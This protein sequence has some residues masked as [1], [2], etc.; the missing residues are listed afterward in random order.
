MPTED[1]PVNDTLI[2][3]DDLHKHYQNTVAVSG[4]N[5][6]VRAGQILGLVGPNGAGKTTIIR[7]ACG[8]HPPTQG[9]I[10]IADWDVV[11][12][13]VQAKRQ[14]AYVPDDPKLFNTLTVWEHL[15]F[16][17][18]AYNIKDE[19]ERRGEALL[20]QFELTEKR[21][22][23]AEEL[24]RGMR[25]KLAICC[26]YL[27]EPQALFLDEPLT[28]LDPRGMRTMKDS[29]RAQAERGSAIVISSHLL[30]LVE[31]MC[32]DLLVLHRGQRL[33]FGPLDQ[34]RDHAGAAMQDATLEDIFLH[35][36]E[37]GTT[38]P[39]EPSDA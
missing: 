27:H 4:V 19:L 26:A 28:G 25:Q 37:E 5:F 29:I 1:P 18:S 36:T 38:E 10:A 11:T 20:T 2:R 31:D 35:M 32:S 7:A 9:R 13:P 6:H 21:H 23:P 30:S 33:Y 3:V 8:I 14:L 12:H 15:R 17:A 39:E 22:T 34:L 24:S 16:I